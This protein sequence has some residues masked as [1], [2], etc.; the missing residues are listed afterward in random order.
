MTSNRPVLFNAHGNR[1]S[2][3]TDDESSAVNLLFSES[4][5]VLKCGDASEILSYR[6]RVLEKNMQQ[7]R[8]MKWKRLEGDAAEE[9]SLS[10]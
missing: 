3:N 7:G 8:D 1:C 2:Q 6:P 9:G 4:D 5:F 10:H